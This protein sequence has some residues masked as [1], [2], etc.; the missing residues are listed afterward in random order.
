MSAF[1][2]GPRIRRVGTRSPR[3]T[4]STAL[5]TGEPRVPSMPRKSVGTRRCPAT[6]RARVD[7]CVVMDASNEDPSTSPHW[8]VPRERQEMIAWASNLDRNLTPLIPDNQGWTFFE[9]LTFRNAIPPHHAMSAARLMWRWKSAW[10]QSGVGL[11]RLLL[12]SAEGHVTGNVHLHA[13]SVCTP[14]A[15]PRH[16]RRC[17]SSE[18][19]AETWRRLKESWYIHYGIARIYPYDPT[20]RT[21]AAGYVAKYVLDENCLD[22]GVFTW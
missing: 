9:T 8:K 1:T 15:S 17:R 18:V 19:Y 7:S 10:R 21:G 20:L 5:T 2:S 11:F 3:P 12:W 14:G 4:R 13:L 6:R 16:C 22:W